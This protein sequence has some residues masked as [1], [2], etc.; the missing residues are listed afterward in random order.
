[1]T[2]EGSSTGRLASSRTNKAIVMTVSI[3][4]LVALIRAINIGAGTER[5]QLDNRCIEHFEAD[6]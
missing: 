5:M 1:M 4:S 3:T 6:L 2:G